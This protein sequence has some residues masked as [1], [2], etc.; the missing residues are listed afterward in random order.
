[1]LAAV[2][3]WPARAADTPEAAE[4]FTHVAG[5]NLADLP[6]FDELASRFGVSPVTQSGDASDYEAH[7]CY[8][9]LDKKTVL[10]FFHGEVDWGFT[11]RTPMRSDRPCLPS[12][13]L[14]GGLVNIAGIELGLKK[15]A[16]QR[17][18]GKPQKRTP[19]HNENAFQYVHKLTDRELN[20]MV[21]RGRKSS[22]P[23][24]DPEGLRLWDVAIAL[25]AS[26]T[27]G[28]LTSFRVDRVEAN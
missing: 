2:A 10:E 14:N 12:A 7:A 13:A 17:L 1:M 28:R 23:Q 9:T 26:F 3:V 5:I 19:D 24:S 6:S 8:Q 25:S 4:R 21:E 11:L 16:Y 15:S 22:Y 20:E 18:V 27:N